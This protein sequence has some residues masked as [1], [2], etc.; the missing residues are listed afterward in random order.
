LITLLKRGECVIVRPEWGP[1]TLDLTQ[2][3]SH[4]PPV[5]LEPHFESQ[6]LRAN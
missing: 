2:F 1:V 5:T 3:V 4:K 6:H